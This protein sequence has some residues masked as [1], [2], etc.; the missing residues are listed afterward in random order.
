MER[1]RVSRGKG[2]SK[3]CTSQEDG[4][5]AHQS[6]Q[7]R[8]KPGRLMG[9]RMGFRPEEKG[10]KTAD[11]CRPPSQLMIGWDSDLKKK[12]L[13]QGV[14]Q[15]HR[16]AGWDSDLKK[17]GLRPQCA[18]PIH[19]KAQWMGFRPEEKGIKTARRE[20]TGE[21]PTGWDSDLKKKG[22]RQGVKQSHRCAGWD[23]D[24]KKKGLRPARVGIMAI[25]CFGWD[26]DLKKKGLRPV[27]AGDTHLVP[28]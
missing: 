17:K 13:R 9:G 1:G 14:K 19:G 6:V 22:L 11:R 8:E 2:V 24:L 3:E 18:T 27:S 4:N 25:H 26:S 15:S 23:S 5:R 12:G 28:R 21:R 7:L 10:I 20:P 16:C